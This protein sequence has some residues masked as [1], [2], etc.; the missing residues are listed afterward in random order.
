MV[1]VSKEI[2][3]LRGRFTRSSQFALGSHHVIAC[4]LA[5]RAFGV[6]MSMYPIARCL[7]PA[8]ERLFDL[9]HVF[10]GLADWHFLNVLGKRPIVLTVTQDGRPSVLRLLRKLSHVA[11]ESE[12]LA[13]LA[14][15]LGVPK[16][17]VSV[18]YPGV[19]LQAFRETPPSPAPPWRI[20]FASSPENSSEIITK[21]VDLL[22]ELAAA[23]PQA[24]V[25][26]LWRPFGQRSRAALKNVKARG[27]SNVRVVY[28]RVNDIGRYF[29]ETHVVVAPFRTVGK[30]TPNSVLEGLASGRPAIVSHRV[31]IGSVL[32][33][34]KAGIWC[35][36]TGPEFIGAFRRLRDNYPAFQRNARA[37]AEKHFDLE[38][39]LY[40]YDE[41]Y[42]TAV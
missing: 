38:V 2:H 4:S 40:K 42:R 19:D 21:G 25:T 1:A 35:E 39:M 14:I 12:Q 36:A 29:A 33:S 7:I 26:I 6:H 9:S 22:L 13:Q 18:V 32:E 23:E 27:L 41:I 24:D 28:G 16:E 37:C 15:E 30:P 20:L 5:R 34:E 31:D 3:Q 8:I 10:T 11:A 17:K